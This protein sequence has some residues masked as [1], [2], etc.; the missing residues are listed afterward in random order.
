[1]KEWIFATAGLMSPEN[2]LLQPREEEGVKYER[3]FM[4]SEFL[5]WLV[6]EG[7]ATTRKEAEQLCHRLM[8]HGIIQ[9]EEN[10]HFLN[11]DE[12]GQE[13]T[14][15]ALAW[16]VCDRHNGMN[17][18]FG[19]RHLQQLTLANQATAAVSGAN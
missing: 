1:M 6:Q 16:D 13:C 17:A 4:A 14:K 9:H 19:G 2:T 10:E 5:D 8:E 11:L 18:V 12:D 3:T 7:E 15:L